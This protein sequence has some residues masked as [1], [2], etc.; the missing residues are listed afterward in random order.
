MSNSVEMHRRKI[1]LASAFLYAAGILIFARGITAWILLP[2]IFDPLTF[3]QLGVDK[4]Q[5]L[6]SEFSYLF[7]TKTQ[8]HQMLRNIFFYL[9]PNF[10]YYK[11]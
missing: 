2:S 3:S 11:L 6:L 7:L 1:S 9:E 8:A 5:S 4:K 10:I